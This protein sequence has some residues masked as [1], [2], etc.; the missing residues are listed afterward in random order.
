ML[1]LRNTCESGCKT[2]TINDNKVYCC[3]EKHFCFACSV[4]KEKHSFSW[5][6]SEPTAVLPFFHQSVHTPLA[7]GVGLGQASLLSFQRLIAELLPGP[8]TD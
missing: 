3:T 1:Q 5:K 8:A 4:F 2:S 7:A 6:F